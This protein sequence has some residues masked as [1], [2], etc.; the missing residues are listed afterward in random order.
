MNQGFI[1]LM[2]N[3]ELI[4]MIT[5]HPST[6]LLLCV[7]AFRARRS[8]SKVK[9]L[10]KGEALIGD[11]KNYGLTEQNYR[12]A[13]KNLEK[14]KILTYRVTGRGTIAKL[15]DTT[16]VD[17]N[18]EGGNGWGNGQPTDSQRMGNG[19]VTTNKEGKNIKNEKMKDNNFSKKNTYKRG[20]PRLV[21][22]TSDN[23]PDPTFKRA[24]G[25]KYFIDLDTGDEY[26]E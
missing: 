12:T 19:W 1:K 17:I 7:I 9:G 23:D 6:F 26:I 18:M 3:P 25:V 10:E 24:K 2:R 16:F 22:L 8:V 4:E 14:W 21:P 11:Y 20:E 15:V 13:K 5:N